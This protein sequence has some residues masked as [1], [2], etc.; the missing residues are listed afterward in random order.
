MG[1]TEAWDEH[2]EA[3]TAALD[4]LASGRSGEF[5]FRSSSWHAR[6]R[7]TRK[8]VNI[9]IQ[10]GGEAQ[11][12]TRPLD[13]DAVVGAVPALIGARHRHAR[14]VRLVADQVRRL[15]QGLRDRRRGELRRARAEPD[16]GQRAAH[17]RRPRPGIST[18]AK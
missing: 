18:I 8:T 1:E 15:A 10:F 4:R 12:V 9:H 3:G 5:W 6:M 13:L 2:L 14:Q 11:G 17:S 7:G 16:D